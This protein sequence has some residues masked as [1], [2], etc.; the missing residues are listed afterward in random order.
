MVQNTVL[1]S[2]HRKR[3]HQFG[4]E[5]PSLLPLYGHHIFKKGLQKAAF[6]FSISSRLTART[7]IYDSIAASYEQSPFS[8]IHIHLRRDLLV[9]LP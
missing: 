2:K 8:I 3:I 4:C 7:E 1:G 5:L 6:A 9:T